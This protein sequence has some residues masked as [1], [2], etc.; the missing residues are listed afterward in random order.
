VRRTEST[1]SFS[2]GSRSESDSS[3]RSPGLLT[4][5]PRSNVE[6]RG[7]PQAP[8]GNVADSSRATGVGHLWCTGRQSPRRPVR[9]AWSSLTAMRPSARPASAGSGG[10]RA[11]ARRIA[12]GEG[13]HG[14]SSPPADGGA[15][16]AGRRPRQQHRWPDP[17]VTQ[18]YATVRPQE[19]PAPRPVGA[20]P[21]AAAPVRPRARDRPARRWRSEGHRHR[22]PAR[23]FPLDGPD[24]RPRHPG[25]TRPQQPSGARR[26]GGGAAHTRRSGR[27][28]TTRFRYGHVGR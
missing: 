10:K 23:A 9:I 5:I 8:R 16:P 11:H 25:P 3:T 22:P 2:A 17:C 14:L 1:C 6:S 27:P 4:C 26:L 21:R 24:L 19:R 28:A 18:P 7:S 12:F 13:A 15:A 20:R